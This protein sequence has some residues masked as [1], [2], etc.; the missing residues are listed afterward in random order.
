MKLFDIRT[1]ARIRRPRPDRRQAVS[2]VEAL[3]G[4]RLMAASITLNP[5]T[6]VLTITGTASRDYLLAR[7]I[8]NQISVDAYDGNG[9]LT[10]KTS[11][12]K[13]SVSKIVMN[14][15]GGDDTLVAQPVSM[16]VALNG[17]DG[18]D[19]LY[20]GAGDDTL[21]GGAGDDVLY[22]STGKDTY[23]F[24]GTANLGTDTIMERFAEGVDTLDFSGFGAGVNVDLA[25][26]G[27]VQAV[28]SGKLSLKFGGTGND[29][30]TLENVIGTNF[31]D[32]I[33][34]NARYSTLT[35]NGG[36]DV[37]EGRG[38]DDVL[39]GGAGDDTYVFGSVGNLGFDTIV[40]SSGRET[41][42]FSNYGQ[43][44]VLDLGRTDRQDVLSYFP[45]DDVNNG[46]TRL[47]LTL[48]SSI[49]DV[50]GSQFKDW[51]K[52]N[53]LS[54]TLYG[55]GGNDVLE[56][57]GGSDT[58]DGGLGDDT[59]LFVGT[60]NLGTDTIVER[61]NQGTDTLDFTSF[62]AAVNVDLAALGIQTVAGGRLVLQLNGTGSNA[63][64][65][66]NVIGT[67]FADTIRGNARNNLLQG[68]GG[69]DALE[70]RGGNDRLEGGRGDDTYVFSG[71]FSLGTDTIVEDDD[72]H[73]PSPDA[74][75]KLDFTNFG[76]AMNV[77]LD[78]N[79]TQTVKSGV[80]SLLLTSNSG[81][82]DVTGSAFNDTIRGNS[83]ANILRGQNGN[84]TIYG[85]SGNDFLYGGIGND[86]L[87]GE[88]GSDKL[89]G[90]AG[91]D[92]LSG[93]IDAAIDD[94]YGGADADIFLKEEYY[95]P[96]TR[97]WKNRDRFLD[98]AAA[99][100]SV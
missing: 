46:S 43:T 89:Y 26:W 33:R 75:D 54:N 4:R 76:Y 28:A 45:G 82:E 16:P 57:M 100:T 51:I 70:G 85:G 73:G 80:L 13:S 27:T 39:N 66:E 1:A 86:L 10:N 88:E 59:Y 94:L 34:G 65:L 36:N 8:G 78:T 6:Q 32:T 60:A 61:T 24:S 2:L 99:D 23:K 95:D 58:L 35:G 62:G 31:A 84:D 79:S 38:G 17:G 97:T 29:V 92:R 72:S 15:L 67:N 9:V 21:E 25:T 40:D 52:G 77:N 93:G 48:P 30:E 49:E 7:E 64:S 87:Y 55:N 91:N 12:A 98:F 71:T 14:G 47:S 69:N 41:L 44:V 11:F 63:D 96:T 37:L 19:A 81:I 3:E 83:R 5:T 42:D 20:G 53:S 74:R 90:E 68:N 22:G 18:N 56:G 50:K